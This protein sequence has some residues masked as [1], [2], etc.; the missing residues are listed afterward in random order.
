MSIPILRAMAFPLVVVILVSAS[1]GAAAQ[2]GG[3]G[4]DRARLAE[5]ARNAAQRFATA[6]A[7][8]Q[9]RPTV[10]TTPTGPN[11]ELSLDEATARALERNLISPS[12][13]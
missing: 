12:S 4:A 11:L 7:D 8:D 2:N 5:L 9:T 3:D 10:P 6:R 1:H 13:A